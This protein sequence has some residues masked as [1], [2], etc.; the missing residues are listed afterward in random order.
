MGIKILRIIFYSFLTLLAII[1]IIFIYKSVE[2]PNQPNFI[3]G[4][5]TFYITSGSMEPTYDVGDLVIVKK[6]EEIK[7]NDVIV[8][9]ERGNRIS[10]RV[11]EIIEEGTNVFYQTKGDNNDTMDNFKVSD[12]DVFGVVVGKISHIGSIIDFIKGPTGILILVSIPALFMILGY[13][14][15]I[16]KSNKSD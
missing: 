1:G 16:F 14:Y 7:V 11:I 3:F 15:F 8:F 6:N 2:K 5:T 9:V 4:H 12:H 10:H 13:G